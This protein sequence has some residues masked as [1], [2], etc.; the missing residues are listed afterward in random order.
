MGN[1]HLYSSVFFLATFKFM[2]APIAG[3]YSGLPFWEVYLLVAFGGWTSFNVFYFLANYFI[4]KSVE[5]RIKLS[6]TPNYKPKKI[7]TKVNKTIVKIKRTNLGFWLIS[8]GAPLVFSIPLGSIIVAKF[9]H[10]H[11]ETYWISSISIFVFGG[12]FTYLA[13]FLK[14]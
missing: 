6:K 9:Y 13:Y 1:L 4:K 5:R 12:I 7:F 14:N 3:V 8:I 11:K 10:H 2:F